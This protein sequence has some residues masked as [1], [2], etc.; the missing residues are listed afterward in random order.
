MTE[1]LAH[2]GPDQH[3]IY[4]DENWSLGHRRLSIID[5]SEAGRQPMSNEDGTVQV[6][7]NG[8]IYNFAEIKR[9][10]EERGHVFT[11]HTDTEVIVHA[12]EEYGIEMLHRFRGMFA[13]GLL[14]LKRNALLLARDRLGI[15]PLY[16]AIRDGRIRFA[17]EIK[18]LLEDAELPRE[19]NR[20]ALFAY[21]GFE[22]VP[23]PQTMFA[24]IAKLPAGHYLLWKNGQA[25]IR[26]FWDLPVPVADDPKLPEEEIIEGIRRLLDES[27][28]YRLIAD[29]P[30]GAFLSGGLDSSSI[31]AIMRRHISGPLRTFTIGYPDKSFSE[32]DYAEIISKEFGTEHH[33]LMIEG[34]TRELIE[35]SL[36][37]LDEPMTDLSSIPLMLIC[38][39]ARKTV[40][41]CLSG[42]GGD[43]VFCGYDRFKASR[44]NRYYERTVPRALREKVIA[45]F[46]LRLKDQPGKKAAV[47]MLKRFVEGAMLPSEGAHLRWQYFLTPEHQARLFN[48]AFLAEVK[49]DPFAPLRPYAERCRHA[50]P[51][52]RE[53]YLDTRFEMPDSVLMKVDKMSMSCA[54]EV[55]VP[56]LDHQLVEFM[57]RVPGTR[58]LKGFQTKHIFRKALEGILPRNIIY[59]GKQGYSLPVKHL[60]R[61]Q[62]RDFMIELL[63][64][65]PV[66]RE[67]MNQEYVRRL[68][69]EH[70]ERKH[71]HNHILW[72]L[73][74]TA[75]WYRRFF[76]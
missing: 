7:Y 55:R 51:I 73:M 65:S 72:G 18:A 35:E 26:P 67:N 47:N 74:N 22:F 52:N 54:L 68:I 43:E 16:Y 8:E 46:V 69:R 1:R 3:G 56:L 62:L 34:V 36:Y 9:D 29:V 70:L 28:R 39:E 17:S 76:R 27:V 11:S 24:G 5:L 13:F 64:E 14:D 59:R 58:K 31:V 48:A 49:P 66:I 6:T 38:R 2:R 44:V 40:E 25:D 57:A 50:D 21:L 41:V 60:L 42:E 61:E 71:N 4:C 37:H 30:L 19:L 53:I 10:L 20:E 15:K 12:W 45:P 33:V 75:I 23:A 63:E 32:L